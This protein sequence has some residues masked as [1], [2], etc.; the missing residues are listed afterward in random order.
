MPGHLS[1]G[2]RLYLQDIEDHLEALVESIELFSSR[3]SALVDWN[4]NQMS[5]DSNAQISILTCVF[6][7]PVGRLETDPFRSHSA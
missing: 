5:F 4:Y 3:A 7:C 6:S 1:P 2:A